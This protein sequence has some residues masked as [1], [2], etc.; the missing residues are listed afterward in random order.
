LK[1]IEMKHAKS[2]CGSINRMRHLL[3][4]IV[5]LTVTPVLAFDLTVTNVEVTQATQKAGNT[6]Q[7][8]AQRG[9]AVRATIG[10]SGSAVPI[11]NVTGRLHVFVDGVELTPATGVP[12]I[13]APFTAPLAPQ[14]A[15]ENDTLNFE[16]PAPN[17]IPASTDV[18]F[19]VDI[20][21]VLGETNTGNNSGAANDLTFVNRT[22]PLLFF[23]RINYS[24]SGLGLPANALIQPS[25]GDA[26]VRGILPVNDAD[27]ELYRE[28]LFPSLVYNG[29]A[30]GD[31]R[32]DALG[33]DGNGLLSLLESCRQLIVNRGIGAN[34]R[35][36]LYG[37]LSGNPING[38]G[39]AGIG[40]RV[41]FGNTEEVRHQRSYAH[42]LT[43]NFG[44][45]HIQ[46]NID[47]VGW[48][49]GARLPNNLVGNNT[50]GRVKPISLF[51]VQVPGLFTNQ[52][53]IWT[54]KYMD[55]LSHPTLASVGGDFSQRVLVVQGI[56]DPTGA[57][58]IQLKPVFR[59]PWVSS[60]SPSLRSPRD[61]PFAVQVTD[62]AG[63]VTK[64]P[65]DAIVRDDNSCSSEEDDC[66]RVSFG[67]FEVMIPL[68]G[69]AS[70]VRIT[71]SSG[72]KVFGGF[73]RSPVPPSVEIVSPLPGAQLD[74]TTRVVWRVTGGA[75]KMFQAAYSPDGGQSFVPIA[76]D[77]PGDQTT[78][79]FDATSIP[80][81]LGEGVIRLFGGDGLNTS[82]VDV[83]GL[84][85]AKIP[86]PTT[87]FGVPATI[88]GTERNDVLIGTP[89]DDVIVGLGT[90]TK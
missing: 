6:I 28:G 14:R 29:D 37:W 53:W 32:L 79:E 63:A 75:P 7:L 88:V 77:I 39:L 38:N 23:T 80:G 21:P 42:E 54:P 60:P 51:D 15:N 48:D 81:S 90:T 25:V 61:L 26:F 27:P 86:S 64:V 40:G 46:D 35:T 5:G 10:L 50:T 68:A 44:F 85:T 58:L 34:D 24:P 57:Q 52:A 3:L 69:E 4:A 20:T 55:L 83:G 45:D 13:N 59:Y 78:F 73:D 89:G 84:S 9:T 62:P 72:V 2:G 16:L 41:A 36:F 30:N 71:N 82:F 33:T 67:A 17:G 31:G 56:F 47:E 12:P 43:H 18:D 22:T 65:F 11:A 19:R 8:V 87:C 66:G 74:R 70:S 1:G 76:V 49:V